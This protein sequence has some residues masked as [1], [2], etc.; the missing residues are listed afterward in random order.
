[1]K[2]LFYFSIALL[3]QHSLCLVSLLRPR[4]LTTPCSTHRLP[5]RATVMP[6]SEDSYDDL[7]NLDRKVEQPDL[8]DQSNSFNGDAHSLPAVFPADG[9]SGT[10]IQASDLAVLE[11]HLGDLDAVPSGDEDWITEMRDIVELKRGDKL[12]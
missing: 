8:F 9:T 5:P 12:L 6:E 4:A 3:L 10:N 11:R 2:G 1:M 7:V